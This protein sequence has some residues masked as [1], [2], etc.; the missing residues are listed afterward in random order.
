[1]SR[2]GADRTVVGHG[3]ERWAGA[4]AVVFL[5]RSE[6]RPVPSIAGVALRG[7]SSN[8]TVKQHEV[9]ERQEDVP[10][11]HTRIVD[12]PGNSVAYAHGAV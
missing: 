10:G 7:H 3:V 9:A 8:T 4:P 2:A 1:M 5:R 12:G 6:F 11:H